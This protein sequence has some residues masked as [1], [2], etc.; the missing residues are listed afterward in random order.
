MTNFKEEADKFVAK[1]RTD[2]GRKGYLDKLLKDLKSKDYRS[3]E[4][5]EYEKLRQSHLYHFAMVMMGVKKEEELC[6]TANA[7]FKFT[8]TTVDSSALQVFCDEL[9]LYFNACYLVMIMWLSRMY[10]IEHWRLDRSRRQ[11]IEM[12]ASWPIMSLGI[13]PFLE[14]IAFFSIKRDQL[15]SIAYETLP[16]TCTNAQELFKLYDADERS[17]EINERLDKLAVATLYDIG[18]WTEKNK[19][20]VNSFASSVSDHTKQMIL[21][22][23]TGLT[24]LKEFKDQFEFR[25]NGGYSNR[26][27]NTTFQQLQKDNNIYEESP[28]NIYNDTLLL[29][30]RFSGWG[31]VQLAT[32]PDP[33]TDESG[34]TG[35]HMI[36]ASD[37]KR[38]LNRALVWQHHP[39]DST[40]IF[41]QPAD[42]LPTVGVN[43]VDMSLLTC[44]ENLDIGYMPISTMQST[45]AV[46]TSGT[47]MQLDINGMNEIWRCTPGQQIRID[48][49]S[50]NERKPLLLGE[51]HLIWQDGEPIDPF[52][53]SVRYDT[54]DAQNLLFQR[55][56]YNNDVG[57]KDM[58]PLQR[59]FTS[60][61]PVGFDS[62]TN[63][64]T[65]AKTHLSKDEQECMSSPDYPWSYLAQRA[66]SLGAVLKTKFDTEKSIHQL[67]K[68]DIIE[69][70][71]LAE[72]MSLVSFPRNTTVS[73]LRFLL[74]YGHTISGNGESGQKEL[75]MSTILKEV[76]LSCD[77]VV[78]EDRKDTNT[79]WLIKYCLG[80]MDTD[81][82]SNFI[83]GELYIPLKV[84]TTGQQIKLNRN[85]TYAF[86]LL[87]VIQQY[88]CQFDKTFWR[89][90]YTIN[91]NTRTLKIKEGTITLT[92]TCEEKND[93]GYKYKQ[94]G[95]NGITNC[96]QTV[97]VESANGNTNFTWFITFTPTSTEAL[98]NMTNFFGQQSALIN[99]A[100]EKAFT[101]ATIGP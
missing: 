24:V 40:E 10:E 13:R 36:H 68:E 83:F 101:P 16:K 70:V 2:D 84:L 52:I 69:I 21:S 9:P 44:D 22:R 65:W 18:E 54:D 96:S 15:F 23:L 77:I 100:L 53:L 81:A 37:G 46:Q 76:G 39:N 79:R 72:R 12:V 56:V 20:I 8:R 88:A 29:R 38:V 51:N 31:Q 6:Q 95:F 42:K 17:E 97:Q 78:N 43:C 1:V 35:T 74:H 48:L 55:E 66:K 30:L 98:L 71:S 25:I 58:K 90:D 28:M 5:D 93:N 14:L 99:E 64:P 92:E 73:W 91:G 62:F 50:K 11:A 4:I 32:D 94:E 45:G 57:M 3:P 85:W 67:A 86:N 27:P 63:I 47:Q 49:L 82:L 75:I 80:I 87:Q 33:P 26:L 89:N 60:R 34:C 41:R 19:S 59:L 61:A 7:S